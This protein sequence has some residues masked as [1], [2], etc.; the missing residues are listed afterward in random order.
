[1]P[2][3]TS[4]SSSSQDSAADSSRYAET[5]CPKEVEVRVRS[6]LRKPTETENNNTNEGGEEV[7]SDPLHDLP[8]WLQEFREHLVD[9]SSP[10]EPRRNPAP[11]HRD[12]PSSSHELPMQWRVKVEPGSGKHSVYTHFPKDPNCDIC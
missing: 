7:Q 9:E 5:Q 1:M 2:I 12:T 4:A 3:P 8:D 10:L 11:G 6:P